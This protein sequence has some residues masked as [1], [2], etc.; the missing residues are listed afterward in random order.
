MPQ[1]FE[2]VPGQD[3]S[4]IFKFNGQFA[5]KNYNVEIVNGNRLK[6]TSATNELFSLLEADVSEVE[7]N[8]MLYSSAEAAQIALQTL[9]YSSEKPQILSEE[10]KR[11][12][13]AGIVGDAELNT[14]PS[15]TKFERWYAS[16]IGTYTNFIDSNGLPIKVLKEELEEF[17]VIISVTNGIA[18]KVYISKQTEQAEKVFDKTNDVRSSTMRATYNASDILFD[19][20]IT[21]KAG[22]SEP[23][24]FGFGTDST[25]TSNYNVVRVNDIPITVSGF[26]SKISQNSTGNNTDVQFGVFRPL[27]GTLFKTVK[28][29]N[30]SGFTPNAVSS[31]PITENVEVKIGD[32]LGFFVNNK[33]FKLNTTVGNSLNFP[34]SAMVEGAETGANVNSGLSWCYTFEIKQ[35]K[36]TGDDAVRILTGLNNTSVNSKTY[37]LED[38]GAIALDPFTPDNSIDCTNALQSCIDEIFNDTKVVNAKI[39]LKGMYR[40]GGPI[41]TWPNGKRSQIMFPTIDYTP[42]MVIKNI[43]II[44]EHAP[45]WEEQSIAEMPVSYAGCGFYSSLFNQD[46][47]QTNWCISLGSGRDTSVFG[48]FNNINIFMDN[49]YMM[50]RS[51]GTNGAP[52]SNT[53]SGIDAS[54]NSNFQFGRM[55]IRT[56]VPGTKLLMPSA[57]SFGLYLPKWNNHASL[58]GTY[59]RCQGFGIGLYATEHLELGKYIGSGN[60]IALY[61]EKYYPVNIG[62]CILEM[63]KKP[64]VMGA[65]AYLNLGVYQTEIINDTSKW[66][67]SDKDIYQDSGSSSVTVNRYVVHKEGGQMGF[68]SWDTGVKVKIINDEHNTSYNPVN[69]YNSLTEL[70]GNPTDGLELYIRSPKVKAVYLGGWLNANTMQPLVI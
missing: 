29:F 23:L 1:L 61:C 62:Q 27:G 25:E 3:G 20:A 22:Y 39:I 14:Q 12:I 44:G 17:E 46:T 49:I 51:H 33:D 54:T 48:E 52:V 59:L 24:T 36:L 35:A 42:L 69:V 9:V 65:G 50:L 19:E 2:S 34:A 5:L 67:Y 8:G 4:L 68:G 63:N 58:D 60:V 10:D 7:I 28:I 53:M 18:K 6:V 38:Y 41:K 30:T 37:Y 21:Q 31:I 13:L 43:G 70:P 32:R 66:W 57:N 56:S 64:I 47:T 16:L 55:F 45:I 15:S 40:I 26:L 11:N